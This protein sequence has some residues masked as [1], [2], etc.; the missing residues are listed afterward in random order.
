MKLLFDNVESYIAIIDKDCNLL[1]L[2]PSAIKN[3]KDRTGFTIQIG[4]KC[5]KLLQNNPEFCKDCSARKSITNKKV[6]NEIILSPNTGIKYWRTC[7][8]L[9]YDGVSGVIEILEPHYD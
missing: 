1:Y 9:V 4:D 6:F 5:I 8:P 2:N 3:Y 7:I